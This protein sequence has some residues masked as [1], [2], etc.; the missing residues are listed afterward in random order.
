[1]IPHVSIKRYKSYTTRLMWKH[2][3]TK[4]GS[5]SHWWSFIDRR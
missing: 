4:F 3:N 1:M 5:H 2:I